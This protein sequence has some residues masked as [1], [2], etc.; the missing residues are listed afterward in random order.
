MKPFDYNEIWEFKILRKFGN[1]FFNFGVATDK[2]M[3][4]VM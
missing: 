4:A 1:R 3:M 2:Q